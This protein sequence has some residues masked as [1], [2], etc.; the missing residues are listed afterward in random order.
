MAGEGD[1]GSCSET[2]DKVGHQ[3][4]LLMEFYS[5]AVA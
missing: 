1:H 2:Q 5:A 3:I 4:W